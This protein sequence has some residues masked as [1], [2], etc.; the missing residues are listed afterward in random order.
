MGTNVKG[1]CA[2][3]G[4]PLMYRVLTANQEVSAD[5]LRK[6]VKD[7]DFAE[8]FVTE[9]GATS[10]LEYRCTNA[11]CRGALS[12]SDAEILEAIFQPMNVS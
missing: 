2:V 10:V 7:D 8:I 5:T 6:C 11:G 4:N 1:M 3:C 12:D 9:S